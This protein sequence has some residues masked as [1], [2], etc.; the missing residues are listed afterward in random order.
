M[1][2]LGIILLVISAILGIIIVNFAYRLYMKIMNIDSMYY[3]PSK[4]ITYIILVGGAIWIFFLKLFM[5][6]WLKRW[7]EYYLL[8]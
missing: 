3:S 7:K 6:M 1:E 5:G 4:K 2:T 8:F